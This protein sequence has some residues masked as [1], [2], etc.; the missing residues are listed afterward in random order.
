MLRVKPVNW[1]C[2][3]DVRVNDIEKFNVILEAHDKGKR[4]R[5]DQDGVDAARNC[6][7]IPIE[8]FSIDRRQ[9]VR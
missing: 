2:V 3:V 8:C 7:S 9:I 4:L 1:P 5:L 6:L